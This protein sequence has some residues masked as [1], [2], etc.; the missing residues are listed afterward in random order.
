MEP[1]EIGSIEDLD[2]TDGY[3]R[4]CDED[5]SVEKVI[6]SYVAEK[7]SRTFLADVANEAYRVLVPGGDLILISKDCSAVLGAYHQGKDQESFELSDRPLSPL[8][9][10]ESQIHEPGQWIYREKLVGIFRQFT[11]HHFERHNDLDIRMTCQRPNHPRCSIV[12]STR[13]KAPY[14][15]VTLKSI[16]RQEVPFSYEVIVVD[17][18]STD[19]TREVC[20][21]Y[22]VRYYYLV[23]PRYRNPSVA[24]NVGYRASR[25]EI[26]LAQSDDIVHITPNAIERLVDGLRPGEFLLAETDN[27]VYKDG[28]PVSYIRQYCGP[29]WRKPYFFLGAIR[30]ED[31][32]AI[33]GCDE[34]FVEPCWDDNWLAD[35]LVRGRMLRPRWTT[36]VKAHHQSHAH[37]HQSPKE[38]AISYGPATH[39]NEDLSKQ[40]YHR[41]VAKGIFCSSG[42]PWRLDTGRPVLQKTVKVVD[43]LP[44]VSCPTDPVVR[45]EPKPSVKV[46]PAVSLKDVPTI[47]GHRIP[48]RMNLFWTGPKMSWMRYLT[49]ASFRHWHPDWQIVLY[50]MAEDAGK[51][52]WKS[53][54]T[55]DTQVYAGPDYS[56]RL[57]GLGIDVVSWSPPRENLA[58]A[59]ACDLCQWE[60]L[61]EYGGW[62]SDMDILWVSQL[63]IAAVKDSPSVFCLSTGYMAIGLIATAPENP[64]FRDIRASAVENYNP[65]KYQSTGAEAI[66]RLADV[67]PAWGSFN[68]PGELAVERFREKYRD[69]ITVL[70]D[71][72]IYPFTYR[73]TH[74]IFSETHGLSSECCGIHWFGGNNLSQEWNCKL[75]HGNFEQFPNTYTKI[76][77]ALGL[78]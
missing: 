73:Q 48:R 7:M 54:E 4:I 19:E 28:K 41:K 38:S 24:R 57:E 76:V 26:I 64:L 45:E 68:H 37:Y 31:L 17:D 11:L 9:W 8:A 56:D 13:N 66:Y 61:S 12:M 46:R 39:S 65:E 70:P 22:P 77:K 52:A 51:K 58:A 47:P 75:T 74:M 78:C 25:S 20:R 35:C 69:R 63:P 40:L 42:G 59:H 16:F 33:G 32:Y 18:G 72:T 49:L 53:S 29:Q 6:L 3:P 62:F 10:L 23:N 71:G 67:W 15:E 60:S 2:V 55:Q 43:V 5:G 1:L 50:W 44:N 14:L 27:W 36:Q 21:R 30:R 34:E